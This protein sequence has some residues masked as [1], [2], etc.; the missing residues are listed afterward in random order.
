MLQ[1]FKAV[2]SAAAESIKQ[3]RRQAIQPAC[4]PFIGMAAA[5]N[6][7]NI[8]YSPKSAVIKVAFTLG[9]FGKNVFKLF[10]QVCHTRSVY[11][12]LIA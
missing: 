1:H 11:N 3:R 4:V 12:N 7:W 5:S 8:K 2:L 10:Y 9:Q 6:R